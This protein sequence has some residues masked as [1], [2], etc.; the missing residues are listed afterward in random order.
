MGGLQGDR[1][2]E[3][4]IEPG[5]RLICGQC[6]AESPARNRN[7][8]EKRFCSDAC[9]DRAKNSRRLKAAAALNHKKP[10]NPRGPSRHARAVSQTVFLALVPIEERA[11]LLRQAAENLGITDQDRIQAA[12]RRAQVPNYEGTV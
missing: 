1:M 9:R 12:M 5:T 6:G 4:Q 2:P 3:R 10:K 11:E 8:V 7:G